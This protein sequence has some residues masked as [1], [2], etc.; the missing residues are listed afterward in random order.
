MRPQIVGRIVALEL[1]TESPYQ[2]P[3][4][5]HPRQQWSTCD[6]GDAAIPSEGRGGT[7][8]IPPVS[9]T[10]ALLAL[11]MPTSAPAGLLAPKLAGAPMTLAVN[12]GDGDDQL[13]GG[14]DDR[15]YGRSGNDLIWGGP[16]DDRGPTAWGR[17]ES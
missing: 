17:G 11:A 4:T 10:L 1:T 14:P 5:R 8:A 13:Q 9:R 16:D 3:V 2:L 7:Y 12:G 6:S 15:L